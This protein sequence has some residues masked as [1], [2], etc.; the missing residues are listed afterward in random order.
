[1][2]TLFESSTD[3]EWHNPPTTS[4]D[5]RGD[6]LEQSC[7]VANNSKARR[8]IRQ[9]LTIIYCL[10]FRLYTIAWERESGRERESGS[11]RQWERDWVRE[12]VGEREWVREW[13][14][15]REWVRE[16][17]GE[18]E[19]VREREWEREREK[20]VRVYEQTQ[21]DTTTTPSPTKLSE[22]KLL[23]DQLTT[24]NSQPFQNLQI[25]IYLNSGNR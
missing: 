24:A 21:T 4:S 20:S 22:R 19:W 13:V 8:I 15:E 7:L 23:T 1:M 6:P 16:W 11:E 9:Q 12:W 5:G 3:K 18:R 17:V 25:F 2:S 14:G 10:M